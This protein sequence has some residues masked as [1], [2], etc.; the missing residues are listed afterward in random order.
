M[1]EP[2]KEDGLRP[3]KVAGL[4]LKELR[5]L[6]SHP[7]L[8]IRNAATDAI[9]K[10]KDLTSKTL[11]EIVFE[12]KDPRARVHGLWAAAGFGH[13]LERLMVAQHGYLDKHVGVLAQAVPLLWLSR[14][15]LACLNDEN[16]PLGKIDSE[17]DSQLHLQLVLHCHWP[18]QISGI[19]PLLADK[20]PFLA[21]AALE[22]LG[23]EKFETFL[24]RLRGKASP[25]MRVGVLLALR[26]AGT[27][28]G[29]AAIPDFLADESPEVRRAAIQWVAEE[30]LHEYAKLLP[31][32]ASREPVTKEL[33]ES[34]LASNDFLSGTK[35][36]PTDEPAGEDFIANILKD[37][38]QPVVFRT[39]A[40][41]MLRPDHPALDANR[42]SDFLAS[43]EP[44]LRREAVR[45]LVLRTDAK[46]QELLRGLATEANGDKSQRSAAVA[47]LAYSAA[48]SDTR[49]LLLSMLEKPELHR[50]ALRSLRPVSPGSDIER[51][52]LDWW[53]KLKADGEVKRELAEQ[54]AL[55]LKPA[56]DSEAA[57]RLD[58]IAKIVGDKPKDEAAWRKALDGK[59]DH[60]AGE[61]LFFHPRGPRCFA[62]HRVDGRGS[63]IG[64]D[65]STIGRSLSRDKLIESI[66]TPSKEIAPQFVS[67]IIF[68]KDGKSRT[69]MIVEEK[70]DST[71]VI[72]DAEG[73]LETIPRLDIEDRQTA[74]TSIMPDNLP[75]LMTRQEFRDLLSYLMERK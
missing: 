47:G 45:T 43:K 9:R 63:A 13:P 30:R 72:A 58:A 5:Q 65:L 26:R 15:E 32:A 7:K 57:K 61:R 31:A 18:T 16:T 56:R 21:S 20:D 42:L 10:H 24:L 53:D 19:G 12:E 39:L 11:V 37:N 25:E 69:G 64:P 4:E 60:A 29:R 6:L 44:G 50:D 28:R 34:W 40:M 66:L 3:S 73:K 55:T 46:S 1:K 68:T 38:K 71:I 70:F 27:A 74:K 14:E 51:S 23:N 49:R 22:A 35:R 48:S 59:G 41:R 75:A 52:I 2:P 33:F 8:E 36:Q 62:C 67:W 54:V 17:S